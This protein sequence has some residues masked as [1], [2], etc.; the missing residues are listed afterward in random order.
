MP[1]PLESTG[2]IP[3]ANTPNPSS[4]TLATSRTKPSI[5]APRAPRAL[6]AVESSSPQGAFRFD[7][8]VATATTSPGKMLSIASISKPYGSGGT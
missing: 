7:S 5:T 6:A 3:A 8:P 4:W 2:L 1:L